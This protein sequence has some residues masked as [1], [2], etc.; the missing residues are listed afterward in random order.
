M[1]VTY[2]EPI[3]ISMHKPIGGRRLLA[4]INL[5]EF[6]KLEITKEG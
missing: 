1:F 3:R 6:C 2:L 4:E 5:K